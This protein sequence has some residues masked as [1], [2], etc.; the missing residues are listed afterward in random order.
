MAVTLCPWTGHAS[1]ACQSPPGPPPL[2]PS[3]PQPPEACVASPCGDLVCSLS[4]SRAEGVGIFRG[5][6]AAPR[7]GPCQTEVQILDPRAFL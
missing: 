4:A 5:R 7:E 1:P 2:C 3:T 6:E